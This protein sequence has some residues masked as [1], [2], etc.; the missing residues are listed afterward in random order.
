MFRISTSLSF[1]ASTPS[2]FSFFRPT[3]PLFFGG[4][5]SSSFVHGPANRGR[6]QNVN[7]SS[8]RLTGIPL[9]RRR[10][11][12]LF[13]HAG[14]Q[15]ISKNFRKSSYRR[16]MNPDDPTRFTSMRSA[17][18]LQCPNCRRVKSVDHSEATWYHPCC[19]IYEMTQCKR[20]HHNK[21]SMGKAQLLHNNLTSAIRAWDFQADRP[22]SNVHKPHNGSRTKAKK[23]G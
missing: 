9:W 4:G 11:E 7:R 20:I 17:I 18:L 12:S 15:T 3:Q 5:S 16:R 14:P 13:R 6:L 21:P 1:F 22:K 2:C 23:N 19:E 8:S 10:P